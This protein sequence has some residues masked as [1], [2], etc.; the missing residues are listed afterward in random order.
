MACSSPAGARSCESIQFDAATFDG[1]HL[2]DLDFSYRAFLA[3]FRIA[4]A[5]DIPIIHVSSG[6]LDAAWQRYRAE[7]L[8]E[9][10]AA[11]KLSSR[12][13]RRSVGRC[14]NSPTGR[15]C[16]HFTA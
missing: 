4:I 16:S 13:R 2:Y 5:W 12:R 8:S 1:F 7:M 15:I 14:C 6:R 3:G 10:S 9:V 11:I